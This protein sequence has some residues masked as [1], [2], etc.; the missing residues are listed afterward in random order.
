MV[1]KRCNPNVFTYNMLI[2]GFCKIG[3]AM[4]GIRILEEMLDNGCLPNKV[5]YNIL[6]EGLQG[7]GKEGEV[8]QVVSMAIS[9]R[10]VGELIGVLGIFF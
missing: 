7:M 9:S 3:N 5:T 6:I 1:E 10:T 4:K 8:R 2:E